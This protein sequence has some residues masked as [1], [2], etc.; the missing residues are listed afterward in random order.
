[1]VK[2]RCEGQKS[3]G[4]VGHV[5]SSRKIYAD[6]FWRDSQLRTKDDVVQIILANISK[7]IPVQ[8]TESVEDRLVSL[9]GEVYNNAVEHSESEYMS[10]Y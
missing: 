9:I 1:M 4:T 7:R 5:H 8:M 6:D 3:Q 10:G 2:A